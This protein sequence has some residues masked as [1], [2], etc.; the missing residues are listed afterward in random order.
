MLFRS[1]KMIRLQVT[2]DTNSFLQQTNEERWGEWINYKI[3]L[4]APVAHDIPNRFF[5]ALITGGIPMIPNGL[6]SHVISAGI[7]K[8]YFVCYSPSDIIDPTDLFGK[9]RKLFDE[10]GKIGCIKRSLFAFE[11]YH[12]DMVIE[13]IVAAVSRHYLDR[14]FP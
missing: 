11:N 14:Y 6:K 7:P 3:H 2:S 1:S 10:Q 9:A 13:K 4:I 12:V 8:E 5:D